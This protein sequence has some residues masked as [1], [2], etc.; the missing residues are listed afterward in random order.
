MGTRRVQKPSLL[1][2]VTGGGLEVCYCPV[3]ARFGI[4]CLFGKSIHVTIFHVSNQPR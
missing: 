3:C 1:L 4:F 2:V